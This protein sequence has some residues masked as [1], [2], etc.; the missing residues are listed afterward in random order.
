MNTSWRGKLSG[1]RWNG[2]SHLRLRDD[3]APPPDKCY[4][5]KS[6]GLGGTGIPACGTDNY[7]IIAQFKIGGGSGK[8]E[9]KTCHFGPTMPP[10]NATSPHFPDRSSEKLRVRMALAIPLEVMEAFCKSEGGLS[11]STYSAEIAS[12]LDIGLALLMGGENRQ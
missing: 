10:S 11:P 9:K 1:I 3:F 12:G 5:L 2:L 4:L 7:H 8:T 6:S